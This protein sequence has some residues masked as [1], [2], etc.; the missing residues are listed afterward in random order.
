M[1]RFTPLTGFKNFHTKSYGAMLYYLITL[2]ILILLTWLT[3]SVFYVLFYAI[4]GYF[5]SPEK[6]ENA[7][8]VSN[9]VVFIP[10]YKEDEVIVEVAK[11][12]SIHQYDGHH[13]VVIIADSLQTKTMIALKKLPIKV[14]KVHF[15]KSTKS[16]AL[17][18]AMDKLTSNYQIAVILDADNIMKAGVLNEFNRYYNAGERAIQGMRVA[19][20]IDSNFAF[21]DGIS[22]GINNHIYSKG[23]TAVN[24]SSRLVGSGMA[25][26]YN[27]FKS[28]MKQIDAIG[29]FDKELELLLIEKGI[30][31]HFRSTA[32]I[33]DEK[34]SRPSD[35]ANQRT[36]WISAQYQ[37]FWKKMPNAIR[38]LFKG[39]FDYF[40]KSLQL[41]LPPRILMPAF[42]LILCLLGIFFSNAYLTYFSACLLGL[43]V[44]AY[45]IAIPKYFWSKK[46]LF[47]IA[48]LP[49]AIMITVLC[50]FKLKKAKSTF[51][52]TPHQNKEHSTLKRIE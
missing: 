4:S 42:I 44:I 1:A 3:L 6:N 21:L 37:F 8:K 13:D 48:S 29:G 15:E 5:Y 51:I 19:K 20:N 11:S 33:Y 28:S 49:K 30:K 2:L 35:F 12:A 23:P 22:E 26:D 25:F 46:M 7:Q 36:R 34:V 16:K 9:I 39:N 24:L 52:N 45:S 17:N 27:L 32:V 47:A 31:I 50:L 40:Y 38:L 14:I 10:A 18:W 41:A 43:N